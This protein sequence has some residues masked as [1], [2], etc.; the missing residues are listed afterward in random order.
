[1]VRKSFLLTAMVVAFSGTTAC[2]RR[3]GN[4]RQESRR[5]SAF[6]LNRMY[7]QGG[8]VRMDHMDGKGGILMSMIFQN[9]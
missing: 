1:M 8:K 9:N 2:G 5:P 7:A 3:P 6:V 4:E